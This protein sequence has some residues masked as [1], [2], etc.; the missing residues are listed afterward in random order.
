MRTLVYPVIH[1]STLEKTLA[2]AAIAADA[3]ANG[4]FLIHHRGQDELLEPA[5]HECKRRYPALAVGIN[6]LSL[7]AGE[8]LR[9]NLAAGLDMTWVDNAGL[10]TSAPLEMSHALRDV[11]AAHPSHLFFGA[12][13]F[14]HQR[15]ERDL[16]EAAR[17][18]IAAGMIPCT[19]G[20]ATG[21]AADRQKVVAMS[22]AAGGRLAIAS[23]ITPENVHEYI[24]AVSHILV[25]T[26][27]SSDFFDFDYERLARLMGVVR[28][29][30]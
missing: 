20:E 9:R 11:L 25:A 28:T 21:I 16:E 7:S 29:A 10:H 18:G 22:A 4:V 15:P 12:A 30:S 14:K 5:A 23:G 3:G 19:S 24:P 26:G 27:I 1:Y 17:R 2:N 13:A 6:H 8:S